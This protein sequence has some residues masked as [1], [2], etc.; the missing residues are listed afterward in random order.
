MGSFVLTSTRHGT[1]IVNRHDRHEND[2]GTFGVGFDLL[3]GDVSDEYNNIEMIK[4]ILT[5]C[6]LNSGDGVVAL[7]LGSNIGVHTIE[8]AKHMKGWGVVHSYEVQDMIY[9][10][11]CGNAVLNN[12]DN[13]YLN[14]LAIGEK[15]GKIKIPKLNYNIP[16]SFGSLEINSN[17]EKQFIGQDFN[18]FVECDIVSIDSLEFDRI[19]FV[20][21][22]IEG[23]ELEALMGMSDSIV[24]FK[25][26]FFIEHNKSDLNSIVKFM[27]QFGYYNYYICCVNIIFV[28][29]EQIKNFDLKIKSCLC[30]I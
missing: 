21:I 25:P 9:Y 16:S 1:M 29:E 22:D 27:Q 12:C 28:H 2:N 3:N 17:P 4:K 8:Y 18:E 7:D 15:C 30:A 6:R 11:L 5:H 23:M 14:K 13:V 24:K 26:F 19:D 20:K 10:A